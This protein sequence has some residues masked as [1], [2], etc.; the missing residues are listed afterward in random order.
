MERTKLDVLVTFYNQEKYV[1]RALASIFSQKCDFKFTVL[2]GDDGSSD[3]TVEI[4]KKWKDQYPDRIE[5][6]SI[7]RDQNTKYIGGFR[8]S[9]NRLNLL[10][11][12]TSDYFI[13]LDG[14]DYY[15]DIHKF[16]KQMDILDNPNNMD[17]IGCSH[18]I[19]AV[20]KD[21]TKSL[22]GGQPDKEGKYS[23]NNYWSNYYFHTDTI[24]F[25]SEIINKIDFKLVENN[26]NDNMITFSMMLYGKVYY[27]PVP[28]AAYDQTGDGIWTGEKAVISNIRNILLFDL[29]NNMAPGLWHQTCVRFSTSWKK[30]Y[31]YR[32]TIRKNEL[33]QF[34]NEA[35]DKKLFWSRRWINYNE[36][37]FW[38]KLFI[39]FI[40]YFIR[41]NSI[42]YKI[43]K[44]FN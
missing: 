35:T 4:A 14:D 19:E 25:R 32:K 1:D 37:S 33:T 21:G 41:V 2:I 3:H 23:L 40:Y 5:I 36:H 24:V 9:Q 29:C 42:V 44:R 39:T 30:L 10:K 43:Q 15:T 8:A 26:F 6:F 11:K 20:Y 38:N 18:Q 13:F 16:Q 17:C 7:G 12:V 27:L 34:Y 31:Q 22:Y 28:M